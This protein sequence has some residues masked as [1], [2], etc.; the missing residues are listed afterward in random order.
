MDGDEEKIE[1]QLH[2]PRDN[3]QE[4]IEAEEGKSYSAQQS[5]NIV[6]ANEKPVEEWIEWRC[7]EHV[8]HNVHQP[9]SRDH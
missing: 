6:K 5:P 8:D 1:A 4:K 9:Y 3:C 7:N 2:L